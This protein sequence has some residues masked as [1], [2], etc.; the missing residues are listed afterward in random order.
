LTSEY[1]DP[2]YLPDTA[3]G[4]DIIFQEFGKSLWREKH[5]LPPRN[6]VLKYTPTDMKEI[7]RNLK[8]HDCPQTHKRDIMDILTEYW[9]VFAEQGLRHPIRGFQFHV[10][11]GEVKPVCCKPPRYGHHEAEVLRKLC[12]KL[13]A[14]DMVEHDDGP[15]GAMIVLAAKP[16]Q[17]DVPWFDFVWRLCVSYRKLNQITRPFRFPF[18]RC[19]DAVLNIGN[20]RYRISIDMDSGYWQVIVERRSR[21]KLAFFGP[22]EKLRWTKMPMGALNAAPVF[23]AMMKVFQL[24]WQH[25]A[26][27]AGLK[28]T[29]SE[30]IIDDVILYATEVHT[31]LQYFRIVLGVLQHYRA[32]VKLKKCHFLGKRQEFV[33]VDIL[34]DGN[35]PAQSKNRA[36]RALAQPRTFSDLRMVIGMF[37]FYATWIP[38]FEDV[39]HPWRVLIKQAPSAKRIAEGQSQS[40]APLW[41]EPTHGGILEKLKQAVLSDPILARPDYTKRF[42]IKTDWSSYGMGAVVLQPHPN[43][44]ADTALR[45]EEAGGP[46]TFDLT[47]TGEHLRL[48]PIAFI[49]RLCTRVEQAY[50]S[51]VGE[52][53][54]GIWGIEKFRHLLF[55]REFTWITDCSG[56]RQFFDGIDLPTHIIQ[57][58]RLQLLRYNFTIVHRPDR[59][60]AEVD[61][62]SRYNATADALR[63]AHPPLTK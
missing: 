47:I 27:L 7:E 21:P 37:G 5:K 24:E 57:R 30:V 10:E 48:R 13:K 12:N 43:P 16:G 39:V 4:I 49:S 35:S 1:R 46:C 11:T 51:Y 38:W 20:G 6:D 52:A 25:K 8:W 58:W 61:L 29:G 42:Y 41:H 18:R 54:T 9:D 55:G 33:G 50:H 3:E 31:L 59:M 63:K 53:A 34:D 22:D 28:E 60:M 15:W 26:D 45:T 44:I 56:L 62:L 32:T 2:A 17:D 14:N 19:D 23:A 36:F 40:L